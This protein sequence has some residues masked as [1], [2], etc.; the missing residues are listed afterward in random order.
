MRDIKDGNPQVDSFELS[1]SWKNMPRRTE[2]IANKT[3][4]LYRRSTLNPVPKVCAIASFC[5]GEEKNKHFSFGFFFVSEKSVQFHYREAT[6]NDIERTNRIKFY[7]R[8][9][10]C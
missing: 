5:V 4:G 2:G 7:K 1:E 3:N 9:S 8:S 6:K 10:N